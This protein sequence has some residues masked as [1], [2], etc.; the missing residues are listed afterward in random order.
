MAKVTGPLLSL[1]ASGKIADTLVFSSWK[2]LRTAR[3]YVVPANPQSAAQSTQ[4]GYLGDAVDE[5]HTAGATALNGRDKE[6][7]GRYAGVLGPM[8][9]FNA[10]CKSFMD[11][12]V[13]GGVPPGSFDQGNDDDDT[14]DAFVGE[15]D[16]NGLTTEVVTLHLG[17]S[18]T[19]FPVTDTAAAVAGAFS[20]G[21]VDTGFAAGTRVYFYFDVGT[22]GT[23]YMRS[24]IY[25]TVLT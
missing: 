1:G 15:G 11:E 14:A 18:L 7:W 9:G 25:T 16:G 10:F 19:F 17:N 20:I 3:S 21:P 2:G 23:D 13:A 12:L 6:A 24:G 22:P 8:S 5:W 4:R